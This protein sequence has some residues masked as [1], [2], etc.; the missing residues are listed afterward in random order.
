[1]TGTVASGELSLLELVY[2]PIGSGSVCQ[3]TS[4]YEGRVEVDDDCI[5]EEFYSIVLPCYDEQPC[6]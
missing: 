3:T 1:M 4:A 5:V 2:P 6:T